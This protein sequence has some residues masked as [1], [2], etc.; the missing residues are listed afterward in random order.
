MGTHQ[1]A[2]SWSA[3]TWVLGGMLAMAPSAAAQITT[4]PLDRPGDERPALPDFDDGGTPTVDVDPGDALGDA[5]QLAQPLSSAPR[6]SVSGFRFAGNTVFSDDA[7]ATVT[8]PW[9]RPDIATEDLLAARNALTSFYIVHGY[10]NSGATVPDQEVLGGVVRIQITEGTLDRIDVQYV[11]ADGR[12]AENGGRFRESYF[13]NRLALDGDAPLRVDRMENRLRML[14]QDRRVTRLDAS[15]RPGNLPGRADLLLQV[16]EARPYQLAV[17]FSNH[18]APSIGGQRGRV[19]LAHE[20]L[21][22]RGDIVS[23]SFSRTGGFHDI[24]AAYQFPLTARDLSIG[25]EFRDNDSVVIEEPFD[26]IDIESRSRTFAAFVTR[27]FGR[28][29]EGGWEIGVRAAVRASHTFLLG[30]GFTFSEGAVNGRA[31]VTALR[32]LL[33]WTRRDRRQV[34][35]LRSRFSVGLPLLGATT[36]DLLPEAGAFADGRRELADGRYVVW[37]GQF[38][39]ARRLNLLGAQTETVAR[40]DAQLASDPLLSIEQLAIGGNASVRGYRENQLVRDSGV[41]GSVEVRFPVI[42]AA[43]GRARLQVGP[44]FDIAAGW[45]TERP[46]PDPGHLVSLG[47]AVLANLGRGIS[48]RA[49]FAHGFTEVAT[50]GDLQDRG[51]HFAVTFSPF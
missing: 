44:L 5:G 17:E 11:E 32:V 47:V 4:V 2:A 41:V 9:I 50:S 39:W 34:L 10:V 7:L 3:A 36:H 51:L 37:L 12:L 25:V 21:L 49:A 40:V 16:Q 38:Q 15:L 6:L 1:P 30:R 31:R 13:R 46:T 48:A 28:T 19:T 8:A 26:T 29:P 27:P 33:D 35:N 24:S 14:Q 18:Q 45:N 20:N 42:R 22:G 23:G 43:D